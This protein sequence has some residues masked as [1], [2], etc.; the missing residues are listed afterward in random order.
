MEQTRN[1]EAGPPRNI[2]AEVAVIGG[3]LL[4]NE[5]L[6]DLVDF[7][8]PEDFYSLRN[9]DIF[10][11]MILLYNLGIEIDV[12]SLADRL[13]KK[14]KFEE[15]GGI[16]YLASLV[17][18]ISTSAGAAYHGN[19]IREVSVRRRLMEHAQQIFQSCSK[20]SKEIDQLLDQAEQGIFDIANKR[21]RKELKPLG[22]VLQGSYKLLEKS[23]DGEI[24]GLSTGLI[25]FD[26]M[27]A[28]LQRKDLIILAGRPAMG[29]TALALNVALYNAKNGAGVAVFSLEMSEE[30]L[31][32]RLI[33]SEAKVDGFRLRTGKLRGEDFD[34]LVASADQI[35]D[36]PI[37]IDD[38]PNVTISELRAK[39]R[40]IE[41]RYPIG[42]IIVDY[43]QLMTTANRGE[44]REREVAEICR[45][46][47]G[48]AKSFDVP[49]LALSQLNRRV[50]DRPKKR[51]ELADLRESGSI[52]QDADVICFL[53][54]PEVYGRTNE[55]HGLA[56]LIVAKQ[57]NGP[58]GV[59][60]L[61]FLDK[62]TRFENCLTKTGNGAT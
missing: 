20:P 38:S 2:E 60:K 32:L 30:Q 35:N 55:N 17:E 7:L 61:V 6:G 50:E 56:E 42:L 37:F 58:I 53:Y 48:M 41:R 33:A 3:I 5:A 54:R 24:Q 8:Q 23:Q 21:I 52:E 9:R 40:R 59:I 22:D 34:S 46:L 31:G 49:V 10:E 26:H 4:N 16:D 51:P 36:F 25:D 44:S 29:K 15:A 28:G 45:G 27:T 43:L 62:F 18:A 19:L 12:V 39:I 57:R 11:A 1:K 14:G 47:K 13:K